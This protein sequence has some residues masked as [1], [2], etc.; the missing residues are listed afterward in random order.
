[1]H[2]PVSVAVS[3][4]TEGCCSARKA[5]ASARMSRPSASVFST[6][7]VFPLR[8]RRT[9]PGRMAEPLGMFSEEGI[10]AITLIF[11][12]SRAIARI[13]ARIEA[14]PPMSHFIVSMPLASLMDRPPESKA[15]PLP[16]SAIGVRLPAPW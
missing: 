4:I 8:W 9:S 10:A 15:T 5:S 2:A 16:V 12:F 1:M 6:S 14:A 3:R 13:A 11:G 7:E